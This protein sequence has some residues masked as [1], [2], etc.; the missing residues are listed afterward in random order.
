MTPRL[1]FAGIAAVFL[2]ECGAASADV[3]MPAIF[4]DHMVLQQDMGV[5]VWGTAD[6]SEGIKVTV[7]NHSATATAGVDG[8]WMVKLAPF[9]ASA[10]SMTMTVTGKNTLRF[11]DVL[12]G[13]VWVCSGQ[14]NM[15]YPL[16][17]SVSGS[18]AALKSQD[19]KLRLFTMAHRMTHKPVTDIEGKWEICEPDTAAAFPA[20]GYF[21][22]R[23]IRAKLGR[24]VGLI[25]MHYGGSSAVAW[26]SIEGL[27]KEPALHGYVKKWNR[28]DAAYA[29]AVANYPAQMLAY[30]TAL[31]Y[32]N[33]Q[34][35]KG[36]NESMNHWKEE[37]GKAIAT[38]QKLP[39][40]PI[41]PAPIPK[42]PKPEGDEFDPS[43][44]YN[45]M[46]APLERYGIRGVIWYQ[47]ETN[48]P[49]AS[50]YRLLFSRL[51]TDWR[52]RW[53]EGDFPFLYVQLAGYRADDTDN[54]AQLREAQLQTLSVPNTGMATA[55]DIGEP[56]KI[57]P[58]DKLDVGKRLALAALHVAY[59]EDIVY[60]GPL[61]EGVTKERDGLRVAF[62]NT[63]SGLVIGQAP[64]TGGLAEKLPTDHLI[65]FEVAG[66]DGQWIPADAKIISNTVL[67]RSPKVP[68]PVVVRYAWKEYPEGNLY[69]KEGLPAS[70][71]LGS[72][73]NTAEQAV[74]TTDSK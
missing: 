74:R 3:K 35:G 70:P 54:W 33:K 12:I 28:I 38:G 18:E 25:A 20:V 50:E 47:G 14:S 65:G 48:A 41:P 4:G 26:V 52:E 6:P 36:Y 2:A 66:S 46:V 29:Y 22:G 69:N 16:S 43:T 58:R 45:G 40:P 34:Y 19:T 73:N 1:I 59:G 68:D 15:A 63:G 57:H 71:F 24:P 51:I 30:E 60:S 9:P 31:S 67:V 5:P 17:E 42:K 55:V 53:G 49:R 13:E 10:E 21:F 11:V 37:T 56:D 64:W 23:D 44:L 72:T 7:G 8:R 62:T 32:W 61:F 27:E 39:A